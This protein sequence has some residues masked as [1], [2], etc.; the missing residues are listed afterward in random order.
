MNNNTATAYTDMPNIITTNPPLDSSFNQMK[1]LGGGTPGDNN[2]L[3]EIGNNANNSVA[4]SRIITEHT[5]PIERVH[6]PIAS[7]VNLEY[8][9]DV[10]ERALDAFS[11][12]NELRN[13]RANGSPLDFLNSRIVKEDTLFSQ[14]SYKF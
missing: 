4:Y 6:V 2:L 1:Y 3:T 8:Q 12:A 7:D 11:R 14:E 9:S 10:I 5:I 13:L